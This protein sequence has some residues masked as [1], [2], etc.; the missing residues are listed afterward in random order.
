MKEALMQQVF[1]PTGNFFS[2]LL[3]AVTCSIISSEA[4][5]IPQESQSTF[6][7]QVGKTWLLL[8]KSPGGS[9]TLIDSNAPPPVSLKIESDAVSTAD[10]KLRSVSSSVSM[11]ATEEM[12]DYYPLY[13]TYPVGSWPE[14]VV[15]G[16]LNMDGRNDVVLTTSTYF[17]PENDKHI[18]IFYQSE[19]RT[20]NDPGQIPRIRY[21]G[22]RCHRGSQYDLHNDIWN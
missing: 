11:M 1:R 18:F 17:D 15:I 8:Q 2:V 19:D 21:S 20:L 22:N 9:L 10:R 12:T 4:Q 14:A 3:L 13:E 5:S 7:R 6:Y 16:D